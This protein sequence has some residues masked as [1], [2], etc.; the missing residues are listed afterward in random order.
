MSPEMVAACL[1]GLALIITATGNLV[2]SL[3]NSKKLNQIHAE[4]NSGLEK[5]REELRQQ[6][7]N[8]VR[9]EKALTVLRVRKDQGGN[10]E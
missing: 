8:V 5:T 1:A 2:V 3:V 10:A 7:A 6:N 9:L 4:T